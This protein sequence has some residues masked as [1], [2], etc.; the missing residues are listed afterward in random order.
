MVGS[1]ANAAGVSGQIWLY[2]P[3]STSIT[4][5]TFDLCYQANTPENLLNIA[6]GGFARMS[7]ADVDAIRILFSSGDI[8]SGT[9]NAYGVVN[10]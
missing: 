1:D 5:G 4:H 7:A 3:A 10:A 8:E 2:N 9:I 6:K